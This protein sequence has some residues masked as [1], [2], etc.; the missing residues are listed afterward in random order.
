MDISILL[1][2]METPISISP[3]EGS[4]AVNSIAYPLTLEPVVYRVKVPVT[5]SSAKNWFT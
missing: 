3:K 4:T 2:R 1:F 5:P